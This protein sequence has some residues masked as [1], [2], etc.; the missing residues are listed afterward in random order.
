MSGTE[1]PS[2]DSTAR[3]GQSETKS[4]GSEA[5]ARLLEQVGSQGAAVDGVDS[6]FGA[7]KSSGEYPSINR[8]TMKRVAERV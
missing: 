2:Y 7:E 8:I 6:N 5:I 3:A 4:G 1:A